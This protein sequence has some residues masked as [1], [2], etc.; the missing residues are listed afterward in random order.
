[1]PREKKAS[2]G[3]LIEERKQGKTLREIAQKFGYDCKT[4]ISK[5]L[6]KAG[7]SKIGTVKLSRT[8][9]GKIRIVSITPSEIRKAGFDPDNELYAKKGSQKRKNCIQAEEEIT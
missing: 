5:R 2:I 8:G 6:A 4:H 1:M 9:N 3:Q 7:H